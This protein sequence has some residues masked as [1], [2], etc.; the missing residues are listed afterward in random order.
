MKGGGD[1]NAP[2]D[3][4]SLRSQEHQRAPKCITFS[5]CLLLLDDKE[6]RRKQSQA[7]SISSLAEILREEVDGVLLS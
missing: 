6:G 5:L 4:W 7:L 1:E 2:K 3:P